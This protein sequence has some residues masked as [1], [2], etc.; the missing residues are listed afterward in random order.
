LSGCSINDDLRNYQNS[1]P[2]RISGLAWPKLEPLGSFGPLFPLEAAP[3][4]SSL[5]SRAAALGIRAAN[6]HGPV[7]D[8]RRRRAMLAA[9]RRVASE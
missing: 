6:L 8:P 9:L 5:A 3:D 1:V 7:L 4:A 2:E